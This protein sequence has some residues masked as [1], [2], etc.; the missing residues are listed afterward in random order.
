MAIRVYNVASISR[1]LNKIRETLKDR[2]L[3]ERIGRLA[4]SHIVARTKSGLDKNLQALEPLSPGWIKDRE[5]L[6]AFNRVG[7]GYSAAK[8][9]LTFTGDFLR[10]LKA[11][12]SSTG[13]VLMF[14]GTHKGYK[15]SKKGK[16]GGAGVTNMSDIAVWQAKEGRDV[17]GV[18]E[19]LKVKIREAVA[20]H[21]RRAFR[22]FR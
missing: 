16:R 1:K 15:T 18:D 8:S 11:N 10:A 19:P 3:K 17:L 12:I 2:E 6:S 4:V 5:R 14:M 7:A 22:R 21:L 9:N 13:V 20:R